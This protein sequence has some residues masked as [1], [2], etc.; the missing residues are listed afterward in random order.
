MTRIGGTWKWRCSH[1][2]YVVS[3][4]GLTRRLSGRAARGEMYTYGK[5]TV[6]IDH[7]EATLEVTSVNARRVVG[8]CV[9][10]PHRGRRCH[11][12]G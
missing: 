11:R 4:P 10:G 3:R 7:F 2:R 8:L 5:G 6:Q 1:G 9:G 12:A